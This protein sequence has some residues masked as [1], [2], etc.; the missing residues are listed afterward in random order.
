MFATTKFFYNKLN[1]CD[2]SEENYRHAQ[3]V[4]DCFEIET[5][6]DY[7]DLY[8][9]SDVLLLCDVFENFR[10]ICLQ[11]YNLDPAWYF[12]AP[13]LSW[14]AMLKM[15]KVELEL[16]T[17]YEMLLFV[18]KGIRGGIS[19]CS[20]RYSKAN[21]KYMVNYNSKEPSNFLLYLDANNLYGWAMSEYLP[22]NHFSWVDKNIDVLSIP[23]DSPLG[24]ILEVDIKYPPEI[25]DI[26]SD[27]P[28]TPLNE[29]PPGCKG[30]RLLTTLHNKSKYVIHYRNLK[31]CL[32][33]GL[34]V[35]EIHRVLHSDKL[36]G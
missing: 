7:S 8:I 2:I 22:L 17:D 14:D 15:T 29:I 34:R 23:D 25:H 35:T 21:N 24:Y 27:L 26:H 3:Q 10:R 30:K 19:Q 28:L 11:T 1:E 32:K 13:G 36:L 20:H 5:L 4:W 18:E 16:L 33:L 31:Q 12:T 9:K 6:G